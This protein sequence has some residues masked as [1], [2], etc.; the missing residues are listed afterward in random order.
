MEY[1][2]IIDSL[3]NT[4]NQPSKFRTTD[5]IEINYESRGTYNTSSLPK[6]KT[7][8]LKWSLCDYSDAYLLPSGYLIFSNTGTL[9][10]LNNRKNIITKNC[11]PFTGCISEINNIKRDNG[12]T[13]K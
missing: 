6:F 1:K 8:M 7:W 12:K 10:A 9:A 11:A 13:L 5:W 4:S 2:K 3:D